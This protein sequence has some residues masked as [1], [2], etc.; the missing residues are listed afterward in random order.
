[1]NMDPRIKADETGLH[2]PKEI[3]DDFPPNTIFRV[4]RKGAQLVLTPEGLTEKLQVS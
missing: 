2:I 4:N 3:I 1:M